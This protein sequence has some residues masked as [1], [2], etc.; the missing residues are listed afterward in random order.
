MSHR[1]QT[2]CHLFALFVNWCRTTQQSMV[3]L[4]GAIPSKQTV[5][6]PRSH[7]LSNAPSP[8]CGAWEPILS[9]LQYWHNWPCVRLVQ[10]ATAAV[11]SCVQWPCHEGSPW[12][13][14]LTVFLPCLPQMVCRPKG[15]RMW[16]RCVYPDPSFSQL[17][18]VLCVGL[19]P[20]AFR[21]FCSFDGWCLFYFHL[22]VAYQFYISLK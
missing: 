17:P 8:G 3:N 5:S 16:Y 13:L 2:S 6:F 22:F 14:S 15:E 10:T 20:C 11:N 4:P 19:R 7:T 12:P 18:I 21:F 1:L 9:K